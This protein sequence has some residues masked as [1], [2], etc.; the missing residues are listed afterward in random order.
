MDIRQ[1]Y[2]HCLVMKLFV[3]HPDLRLL[4]VRGDGWL[5]QLFLNHWN[6]ESN[7]EF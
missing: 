1:R 4:R 7:E 6:Q 2:S 3:E 5:K